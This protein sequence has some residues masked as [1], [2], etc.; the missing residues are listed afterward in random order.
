MFWAMASK[1]QWRGYAS[2]LFVSRASVGGCNTISRA[3]TAGL[4]NVEVA[5]GV[6]I[7][8]CQPK[9]WTTLDP[10]LAEISEGQTE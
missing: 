2:L 10:G 7:M 4:Q 1:A 3:G 9:Q 5:K 6:G 8:R